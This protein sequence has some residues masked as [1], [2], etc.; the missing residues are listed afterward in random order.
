VRTVELGFAPAM[1]A[2]AP[3]GELWVTDPEGKRV[4]AYTAATPEGGPVRTMSVGDGAHAI[5][6]SPD[7]TKAYV[8]NQGAGTV[9]VVEVMSGNVSET[10]IVGQSPNGMAVRDQ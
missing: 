6:F 3:T 4:V 2:I 10:V 5:A 7:G 8:T 9:S 1:A